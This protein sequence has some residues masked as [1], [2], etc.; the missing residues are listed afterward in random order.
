MEAPRRDPTSGPVDTAEWLAV[1]CTS[2]SLQMRRQQSQSSGSGS[3][4]RQQQHPNA[5]GACHDHDLDAEALSSGVLDAF[6]TL[7]DSLASLLGDTDAVREVVG[8]SSELLLLTMNRGEV[9]EA[10]RRMR[11]REEA[12]PTHD[13]DNVCCANGYSSSHGHDSPRRRDELSASWNTTKGRTNPWR[14]IS[15][16]S[17]GGSSYKSYSNMSRSFVN[18]ATSNGPSLLEQRIKHKEEQEASSR[19]PSTRQAGQGSD[20]DL[21]YD[22]YS[23]VSRPGDVFVTPNESDMPLEERI[24]RKVEHEDNLIASNDAPRHYDE[25][26]REHSDGQFSHHFRDEEEIKELRAT[27]GDYYSTDDEILAIL[28][29]NRM[30]SENFSGL[31]DDAK[32]SHAASPEPAGV[33]ERSTRGETRVW[34]ECIKPILSGP[35]TSAFDQSGF[36]DSSPSILE[37]VDLPIRQVV[38][39]ERI[40]SILASRLG[41]NLEETVRGFSE[42][43]R[44]SAAFDDVERR[45]RSFPTLDEIRCNPSLLQDKI[46]HFGGSRD[47]ADRIMQFIAVEADPRNGADGSKYSVEVAVGML[48][49]MCG[50]YHTKMELLGG[51]ETGDMCQAK[52]VVKT[53]VAQMTLYPNSDRIV[54]DSCAILRESAEFDLL[55]RTV[56]GCGGLDQ[57]ADVAGSQNGLLAS[58]ALRALSAVVSGATSSDLLS[59][60]ACEAVVGAMELHPDDMAVQVWGAS[61]AWSLSAV[62]DVEKVDD[63]LKESLV[64]LGCA[65]LIARAMGRFVACETMQEKGIGAVWSLARPAKTKRRVGSAAVGS[66]I[67]GL[68]AFPGSCQVVKFGLGCLKCFSIDSGTGWFDEAIE[69][70][71]SCLWLHLNNPALSQMGLAALCNITIKREYKEVLRISE[72]ELEIVLQVMLTHQNTRLVQSIA[73]QALQNLTFSQSNLELFG[74]DEHLVNAVLA[75]RFFHPE[76]FERRDEELL[77]SLPSWQQ[78]TASTSCS[79]R[80][81]PWDDLDDLD[82]RVRSKIDKDNVLGKSWSDSPRPSSAAPRPGAVPMSPG[83]DTPLDRHIQKKE[84]ENALRASENSELGSGTSHSTDESRLGAVPFATG[85]NNML[86]NWMKKKGEKESVTSQSG[87]QGNTLASSS[88]GNRLLDERRAKKL[89]KE[90]SSCTG[91]SQP[92][93]PSSTPGAKLVPNNSALGRR[94]QAKQR[95]GLLER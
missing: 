3:S 19:S 29:E 49:S 55:R 21:T 4:W 11:G 93:M 53:I 52:K 67:N 80:T 44:V 78:K 88:Q 59:S 92:S 37:S 7:H 30:A 54:E 69:L 95:K 65:D 86:D 9:A 57:L 74:R 36:L 12:G 32:P 14:Q 33:A 1:L 81:S 58:A 6:S 5:E 50:A 13:D 76:G 75:A 70:V 73:I 27:L 35:S 91:T 87:S 85:K 34:D 83:E 41:R 25:P 2:V 45:S 20:G 26:V 10:C 89:E 62:D 90:E 68:A 40:R 61:A 60:R 38:A 39:R 63:V 43:D 15:S 42:F 66:V 48:R 94:V 17:E 18:P 79:N 51:D 8:R 46:L 56:C 64:G 31:L 16:N 23:N 28:D 72:D 71:Y 24:Q 84:G 47:V 82:D 77:M 22:P